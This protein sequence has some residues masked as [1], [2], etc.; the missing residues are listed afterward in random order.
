M[1]DNEV[2]R[3]QYPLPRYFLVWPI[4]LRIQPELD[5]L[6]FSSHTDLVSGQLTFPCLVK[7]A[8]THFI[9]PELTDALKHNI[10]S[11]T[12][13]GVTDYTQTL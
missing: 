1:M 3:H 10:P 13:H 4:P 5:S 9:G 6:P 11:T 8:H 2:T 7:D 12:R